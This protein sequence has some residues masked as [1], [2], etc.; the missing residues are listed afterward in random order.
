MSSKSASKMGSSTILAAVWTT[1]SRMVG[2]PSGRSPRHSAFG[3]ITRR[4]GSGRYVFETNSSR[5]PASHAS[6]PSLLDLRESHPIHARRSRIGAGEPVGV[7]QDVL[8]ADLVVEHIEAEGGLRLRLA[9]EL[10]LKAPDLFRCFKAHRQSPSPLHLR[11]RTRSQGPLLHR[12]YPASSLE[13]PC[14]TPAVTAA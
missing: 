7:Q 14:P 1:R 6:R 10:S 4:T 2:M 12:H 5:K 9:I 13:R 8:A 11:K 3:I